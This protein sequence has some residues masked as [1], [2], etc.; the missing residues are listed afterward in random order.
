MSNKQLF[1]YDWTKELERKFDW[2]WVIAIGITLSLISVLTYHFYVVGS[3][4]TL[5]QNTQS[6]PIVKC[7]CKYLDRR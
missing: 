7:E 4:D 1:E 3:P 6:Q 5:K 2:S